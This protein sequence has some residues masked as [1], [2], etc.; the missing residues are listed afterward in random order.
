[1]T[2]RANMHK[3][4]LLAALVILF[5]AVSQISPLVAASE[6]SAQSAINSAKATLR[7]CYE[8]TQQLEDSGANVE[9][10]TQTLN[11]AAALLSKAELAYAAESYDDAANFA[12]QSRTQLNGFEAEVN[13]QAEA[14]QQ[15]NTQGVLVMLV[16]LVSS[17][18]LLGAGFAIWIS[19]GKK[20]R[21]P[22]HGITAV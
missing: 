18:A 16:S 5:F 20:Q 14:T 17:V 3:T 15:A 10:L 4:R 7:T 9:A 8:A 2:W 21:S 22:P 6:G 12:T 19:L 11:D 1:M 13:T